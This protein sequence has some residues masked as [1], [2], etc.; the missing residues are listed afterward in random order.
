MVAKSICSHNRWY[1]SP[2][3]KSQGISDGTFLWYI[4]QNQ[5]WSF[6]SSWIL[7]LYKKEHLELSQLATEVLL[8]FGMTYLCEKI[9]LAMAAI[10]SK[11]RNHFQLESDLR[12]AVS[13]I[14]S[15]MCQLVSNM[16]AHPS[17]WVSTVSNFYTLS[18]FMVSIG[19]DRMI[20]LVGHG[21]NRGSNLMGNKYNICTFSLISIPKNPPPP[22]SQAM[23]M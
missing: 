10:K 21:E 14:Q 18:V 22:I 9:F 19:E 17:H 12:V 4:S 5:V 7:D 8:I 11:Y 23:M 1:K 3:Y 6:V 2:F 13:M 20:S 16:Q 15:R